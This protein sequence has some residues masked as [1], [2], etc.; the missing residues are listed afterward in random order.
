MKKFLLTA[1]ILLTITNLTYAQGIDS[2][3]NL[4]LHFNGTD[5]STV[6]VDSSPK[7]H[8]T[9][10]VT[11]DVELDTDEQK[12]GNASC[13]FDGDSGKFTYLDSADWSWAASTSD[14]WTIDCWVKL[15]GDPGHDYIFHNQTGDAQTLLVILQ[16]AKDAWF[17]ARDSNGDTVFSLTATTGIL[18]TN[19]H[20]IAAIKD[21]GEWGI[22]LDGDQEDY[23]QQSLTSDVASDFTIGSQLLG[24]NY[25][26]GRIDEFRV[27]NS[28]YFETTPLSNN[29]DTITVPTEEY[30][31][32]VSEVG[33]FIFISR[34]DGKGYDRVKQWK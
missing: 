14:D 20:H 31:E 6:F 1:L 2:D 12:W 27:Q 24:A 28:N 11:A 23:E 32:A 9:D 21:G 7:E 29:S 8:T 25:F 19:W 22:Y 26:L 15:A 18:D 5:G 34:L 16:T 13:L 17:F 4:M 33:Q 10:S 3:T 30:S